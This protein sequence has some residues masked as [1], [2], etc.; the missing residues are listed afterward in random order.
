MK[1]DYRDDHEGYLESIDYRLARMAEL[2]LMRH[3]GVCAEEPDDE[4]TGVRC[5]VGDDDRPLAGA[6]QLPPSGTG[7]VH[8]RPEGGA[9]AV[10][11]RAVGY[12]RVQGLAG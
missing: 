5:L 12:I 11:G 7:K 2:L 9:T 6:A 8:G 1:E 4:Q 10:A 3:S